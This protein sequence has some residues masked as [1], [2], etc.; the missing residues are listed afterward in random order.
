[1]TITIAADDMERVKSKH[2][3]T[4]LNHLVQSRFADDL[5]QLRDQGKFARCLSQDQ[6]ANCSTWHC[7]ELNLRFIHRAR[8]N[9][10]PLNANKSR[11]SNTD[12]ACRHCVNHPE[13]F[14]PVICHSHMVNIC[15]RH[16]SVVK[17]L[18][19]AIRFGKITTDRT[20]AESNLHLR[21]DIVVDEHNQVLLIDVTCPFDNDV[22]ALRNAA[23]AKVTKYQVLKEFIESKGKSCKVYPFVVGALGSWFKQNEIVLN[24]LGMTRKYKMLFRKLCCTYVIQGSTDN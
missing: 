1:M 24:K 6:Y 7:T 9:V 14:P 23:V 18:T 3:T 15:A 21:P 5:M 20:V 11:Y 2:V 12:T 17:R 4:F 8:L 13:T 22:D 19:N 10:E 16:D